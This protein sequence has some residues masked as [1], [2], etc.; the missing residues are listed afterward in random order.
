MNILRKAVTTL[1]GVFLAALLITALA[2]RAVRGIAATLVQVTNTSANPVPTVSDDANFPYEA[3]IAS[4]SSG[5]SDSF[6]V[7]STTTTGVPVKRLVIEDLNAICGAASP[8]VVQLTLPSSADGNSAGAPL[9]YAFLVTSTDL[10]VSF[11]HAVV[12][13]YADPLAIVSVSGRTGGCFA[14]VTGHLETK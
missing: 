12:R 6:S 14:I 3:Q 1:G 4:D 7:P 11:G 10:G 9:V 8:G 5:F 2:P 13:I